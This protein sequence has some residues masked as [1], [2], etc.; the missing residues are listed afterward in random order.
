MPN[1]SPAPACRNAVLRR[2][3]TNNGNPPL[4]PEA[5]KKFSYGEVTPPFHKGR[6]QIL[7]LRK[8]SKSDDDVTLSTTQPSFN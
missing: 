3:G 2:A 8:E 4:S 1:T 6:L 7:Y 5:V